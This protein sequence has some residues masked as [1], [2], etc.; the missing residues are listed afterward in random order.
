MDRKN[1]SKVLFRPNFF[2]IGRLFGLK[3][4]F[5]MDLQQA[6]TTQQHKESIKTT[7]MEDVSTRVLG[8][9]KNI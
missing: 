8:K 7:S 3:K 2:E 9:I 5:I 4:V 1:I 6:R